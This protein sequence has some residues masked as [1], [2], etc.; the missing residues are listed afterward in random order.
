MSYLFKGINITNLT[1]SGGTSVPGFI[2]FPTQP[3]TNVQPQ[4]TST[5]TNPFPLN[6]IYNSN[7]KD[8]A[9]YCTAYTTTL[10][11]SGTINMPLN[12]ITYKHISAY[13]WGGGGGGG[14][15]GGI[16]KDGNAY[17]AGG[18][19]GGG[20]GNYAGIVQ[21]P[22]TGAIN[23]TVGGGGTGGGGGTSNDTLGK[24]AGDGTA[25]KAGGSSTLNV[26]GTTILT[27]NGGSGGNGGNGANTGTIPYKSG[28]SGSTPGTPASNVSNTVGNQRTT[29]TPSSPYTA[30]PQQTSGGAGG[31]GSAAQNTSPG[32]FKS[33]TSGGAG[34]AGYLQIYFLYQ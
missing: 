7:T 19:A 6:Y 34:A 27:A 21:V 29:T 31:G 5:V 20:S 22:I 9:N 25:G 4:Y 16:V 24:N 28:T 33:A 23:Y 10:S 14:G 12:S 26:A 17:N 8:V 15:G 3:T 2:G 18:G 13:G 1:T 30:W 32:P 11:S